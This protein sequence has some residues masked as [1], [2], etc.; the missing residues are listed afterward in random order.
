MEQV[1]LFQAEQVGH[2]SVEQVGL[3][4]AE[5]VDHLFLESLVEVLQKG[6]LASFTSVC[7]FRVSRY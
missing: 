4:Q 7:S 2:R 1:C 5:Q 3:F 6:Q